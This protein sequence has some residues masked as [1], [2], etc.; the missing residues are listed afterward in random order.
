MDYVKS[1]CTEIEARVLMVSAKDVSS[2]VFV[3]KGLILTISTGAGGAYINCS[4]TG[5]P[6]VA[7]LQSQLLYVKP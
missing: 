3:S 7:V 6:I 5:I 1:H 4:R 2:S